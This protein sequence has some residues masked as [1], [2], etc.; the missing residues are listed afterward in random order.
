M[1]ARN[2]NATA[3]LFSLISSTTYPP[4]PSLE[5]LESLN[6]VLQSQASTL[7]T[8][9]EEKRARKEK[10]RKE[11]EEAAERAALEANERTRL[12][13]EATER[14][15][16]VRKGGSPAGFKVKRERSAS[17]AGS[18]ASTTSFK[19]AKAPL[20]PITYVGPQT[21]KK[22]TKRVVDS[23][24]ETRTRLF[25]RSTTLVSDS[26]MIHTTSTSGLK[27]K[28]SSAHP[29]SR[30]HP[31]P[32]PSPTPSNSTAVVSAVAGA[33]I[34]FSLPPHPARALVPIR[35]GVQKP[36]K[37]GPKR[38]SEVD[39][40]FSNTKAPNQVAFTTF[41]SSVEPYLRDVREDDLAML[42]F[43]ADAPESY[44]I[45]SRGR[46]YSEVWDEE[47]EQPLGT[48]ARF[49]VPNWR[50]N[51]SSHS[52]GGLALPHFVPVVEMRDENLL[53][54][55]RGLGNLTERIVAAVVGRS[56]SM[57]THDGLVY[58]E[59]VSEFDG[60]REASRVDVVELEDRMKKELRA[61]MLLGEHE[62]FDPAGRD[63]DEIAS[64]L[65][66]CQ[67]LLLQQTN[68]N[69]A[70][71]ARLADIARNRLAFTE[72]QSSLDGIEKSI[73]AG[74][75]KRV[76]KYGNLSKRP[77]GQALEP[78]PSVPDNLKRLIPVR[79][80]WLRTVGKV[81]KSRPPG[82]VLGLPTQ[83]I[84][85]GIGEETEARDE[86]IVEETVE[87]ESMDVDEVDID[88][89]V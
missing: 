76:K 23:D 77:A 69:D 50:Q 73:E 30:P 62:E 15:R 10:K 81:M 22:K 52:H 65:R 70:R 55:H 46:H 26:H 36:L 48:T 54:E 43:K 56:D 2:S 24:D 89:A 37:P 33:A 31:H 18:N 83:S 58:K 60:N 11:R 88:V 40:D 51:T 63:D 82:E 41:W 80:G 57:A 64:A 39:E 21:K 44:D 13:L 68:I 38:Q 66:Q 61:L 53:D 19:L 9:D 14:A 32:D 35:P 29:K 5:E 34:D 87:V 8:R 47:D 1:A 78:R 17:P 6:S 85:D 79:N 49:P 27:L 28:L 71:K 59:D 25:D 86:K 74:W 7:V 16:I 12:N 72:Y 42:G 20:A 84:Y 75:A 67:R 45:P 4:L 3:Y